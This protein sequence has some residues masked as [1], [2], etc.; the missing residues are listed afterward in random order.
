MSTFH[1]IARRDEPTSGS[2]FGEGFGDDGIEVC[3]G[4]TRERDTAV[5]GVPGLGGLMQLGDG[6]KLVICMVGVSGCGK[7]YFFLSATPNNCSYVANKI[8]RFLTWKGYQARVF[9]CTEVRKKNYPSYSSPS[10]EYWNPNNEE[11]CCCYS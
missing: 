3:P 10:A 2:R 5:C 4:R 8:R 11:V 7:T 9:S 6:V 1:R